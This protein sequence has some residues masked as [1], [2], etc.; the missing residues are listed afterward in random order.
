M[1]NGF[2][3]DE[4]YAFPN[5]VNVCVYKGAC[6]CE[7]K[8]CP[9]GLTPKSSRKEKFGERSIDLP[10]FRKIV[11][12]IS[13]Y[14]HSSLRIHSVGEP[15]LWKDLAD[16]LDYL[17][18]KG[19]TSW[20]F[21]SLVTHD[22]KLLSKLTACSIIEV[23]VNSIN[24]S[25][26]KLTKG[27]EGFELVRRNI[28]FLSR[29]IRDKSLTTRLIV[30]R[31]ES[32]SDMDKEFVRY[33]KDTGLVADAFVRSFHNY[34]GAISGSSKH[35]KPVPC[36]VHWARFNVNYDGKVIVCFNELFKE[37]EVDKSLVL[38]D[39]NN[40]SIQEIWQ[41]DKLTEIRKAQLTGDYSHTSFT[42]NLPCLE[43][44]YCQPKDTS[45]QTSEHQ[46]GCLK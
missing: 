15:L 30:S 29:S 6:P 28:E 17:N 12:D 34:N 9:V 35:R 19:V 24:E 27:I 39:L 43:C 31:V 45:R 3:K 14:P 21:T 18:S 46:M 37:P 36:L 7:C 22:K 40:Y 1:K 42:K 4:E 8:H 32:F 16:A 26:Y 5:I 2:K 41:G 11:D 44:S 13:N 33:W 23:S 10:L 25:D 38:G 20:L